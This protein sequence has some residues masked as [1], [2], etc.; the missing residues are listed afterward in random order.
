M[1]HIVR[2]I[3]KHPPASIRNAMYFAGWLTKHIRH[4][5]LNW[6]LETLPRCDL[7]SIL[8]RLENDK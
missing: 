8:K 5:S 3:K 6:M 7:L 1:T 2:A 4:Q